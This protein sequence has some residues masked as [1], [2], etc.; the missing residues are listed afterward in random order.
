MGTIYQPICDAC[1]YNY[2][3]IYTGPG[4][5]VA[6]SNYVPVPC[7][8][9]KRLTRIDI[10]HSDLKC[11]RCKKSV[12]PLKPFVSELDDNDIME[13]KFKCPKCGNHDLYF[14]WS[15]IWD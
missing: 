3:E 14:R 7:Y 2:K 5:A 11:S 4:M 8:T 6:Y 13:Y 9:C 1:G 15:G 12:E 10:N